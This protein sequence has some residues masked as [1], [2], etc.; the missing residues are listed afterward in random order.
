MNIKGAYANVAGIYQAMVP[1]KTLM[2]QK[3]A[4]PYMEE[5]L[6]QLQAGAHVLDAACGIGWDI[7]AI[8]NGLPVDG[9]HSSYNAYASDGAWPMVDAARANISKA[10]AEYGIQPVEV[11]HSSFADLFHQADWQQKFDC[12]IAPNAINQLPDGMDIADYDDYILTSLSGLKSTV[13]AD[14][15]LM[16]DS[17][18][19]EKTVAHAFKTT[20]REN[21]HNGTLYRAEYAWNLGDH[22][23]GYHNANM[24]ITKESEPDLRC[25]ELIHFS[26]RSVSRLVELF[27][28][29]GLEVVRIS[30]QVRGLNA[31]PFV[32]FELSP[33]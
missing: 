6:R 9:N 27:S 18:D 20:V 23:N 33:L 7:I 26:G 30:P 4:N 10:Q 21:R 17:R 5:R 25:S 15:V 22:V 3:T 13:K 16:L 24:T 8:A 19:W 11:R 32:T 28:E 29:A 31:E 12:V 2:A 1:E 14:G